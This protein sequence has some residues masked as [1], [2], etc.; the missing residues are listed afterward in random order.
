MKEFF[1]KENGKLK[2][3]YYCSLG[4][5]EKYVES[6]FGK[7]IF[8]IGQQ[9]SGIC[10]RCCITLKM[11]FELNPTQEP[12]TEDLEKIGKDIENVEILQTDVLITQPIEQ[13]KKQEILQDKQVVYVIQCNDSTYYV[14]F[15]KD[16]NKA[17]K[18]HKWGNGSDYTKTRRPLTLVLSK[19][20]S[21]LE[22]AKKVK[23]DL[24]IEYKIVKR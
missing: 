9:D 6:Q 12:E 1:Y 19:E 15:T 11:K 18:T 21:S 20:V 8:R 2:K 4:C 10:K 17:F 13:K 16:V 3:Y 24:E 22:E 7:D 23:R 5:P 14:G